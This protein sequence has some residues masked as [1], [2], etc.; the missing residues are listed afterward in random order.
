[1]ICSIT[2]VSHEKMRQSVAAQTSLKRRIAA[3]SGRCRLNW[4]R[5]RWQHN[6]M[7]HD[8]NASPLPG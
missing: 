2:D 8:R 7:T 1:M 3:H 4:V 6:A 5:K